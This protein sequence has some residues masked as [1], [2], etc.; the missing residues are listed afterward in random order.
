MSNIH[1]TEDEMASLA[2]IFQSQ[3]GE[4]AKELI[5]RKFCNVS[6]FDADPYQHAFNAGQRRL[7]LLLV[8]C[9]NSGKAEV[10]GTEHL[11]PHD[12][13]NIIE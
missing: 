4:E 5:E 10:V 13:D 1:I 9:A 12:T 3:Y 11:D 7:A 6:D 8:A 2:K